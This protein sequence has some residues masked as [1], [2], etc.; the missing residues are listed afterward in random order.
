[1]SLRLSATNNAE[2]R[3]LHVL[4]LVR[5]NPAERRMHGSYPCGAIMQCVVLWSGNLSVYRVS[6]LVIMLSV[7]NEIGFQTVRFAVLRHANATRR[8]EQRCNV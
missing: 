1:M 8:N 6:V 4:P 2:S 3:L 5:N 7:F